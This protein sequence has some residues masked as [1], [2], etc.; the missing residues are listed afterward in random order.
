MLVFAVACVC[1]KRTVKL[2]VFRSS[3]AM[4]DCF[5]LYKVQTWHLHMLRNDRLDHPKSSSFT[6]C[7]CVCV[8][9]LMILGCSL[10]G[11]VFLRES[12]RSW[13]L[14]QVWPSSTWH[15]RCTSAAASPPPPPA[16]LLKIAMALDVVAIVTLNSAL[17]PSQAVST[18]GALGLPQ[19]CT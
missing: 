4:K 1:C 9:S 6:E 2:P 18:G 17:A 3:R 12:L 13:H 19:F 16:V 8:T 7:A 15:P 10:H 11:E 14:T 5:I